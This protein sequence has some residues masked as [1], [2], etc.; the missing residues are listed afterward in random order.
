LGEAGV[1]AP[2]DPQEDQ[3]LLEK[4]KRSDLWP[5]T[6]EHESRVGGRPG[7]PSIFTNFCPEVSFDT[8]GWFGS[9]LAYHAGEID[10]DNSH[11]SLA[12][13]GAIAHDWRWTFSVVVPLHYTE[14][15]FYSLL[16][17]GINE[18]KGKP[19]IGFN[20]SSSAP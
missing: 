16:T 5:A 10:Q 1:A 11:R 15:P 3:R 4:W 13:E 8:F 19:Q 7:R 2:I 9:T 14:C 20:A 12:K 18:T 6:A 17:L